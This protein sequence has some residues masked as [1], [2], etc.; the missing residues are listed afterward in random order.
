M[1][2]KCVIIWLYVCIYT[3]L[4]CRRYLTNGTPITKQ[5][6]HAISFPLFNFPYLFAF[7]GTQQTNKGNISGQANECNYSGFLFYT[8]SCSKM[9]STMFLVTNMELK[10][11]PFG[12]L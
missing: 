7:L 11:L 2:V 4:E 9:A 6:V 3:V 8:D 5:Y 1:C 12:L 10:A